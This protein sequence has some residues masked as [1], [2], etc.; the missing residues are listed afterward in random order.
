MENLLKNRIPSLDGLRAV[1]ILMVVFGHAFK[2]Y[3]KLID[4]ANLGVRIFFIISAY[5]IVGILYR[6]VKSNKFSIKTFYF[7]RLVRTFPAFYTYLLIV[8]IVLICLNL[9][10]FEQFWRAPIYLENYHPR[11]LWN[12]KQWFVGHTW[13]LAVEEQFYVL[14]AV[15]FLSYYKKWITYKQVFKIFIFIVILVPLIR[16][17]Y[18]YFHFIP[19]I[20]RG[21]V[22]RSFET[23]AD[24]LALG[25]LLAITPREKLI[26]SKAFSFLKNKI[27]LLV[28]FLLF[29]QMLNSS[30]L[31]D[32]LGLKI[33]Y[34]YNLFGLTIINLIIVSLIFILINL[35]LKSKVSLLL[36][37]PIMK[38]IG[39]WSYSIYL[40][41]QIWLYSWEI[42]LIFKFLGIIVSSVLSYYLIEKIFLTWRDTYLEKNETNKN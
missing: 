37:H 26:N 18:M 16:I 42:P 36:N 5:L 40:W 10:E 30:I 17:S 6:D 2:G 25:G 31:V 39:L 20:L 35:D 12:T 33:R 19:D 38:T 41:Q 28:A 4:I 29:F 7:K 34:I 15:M 13:S 32:Y 11:S 14:I 23:V 3:F 22:H 27:F 24:S 1:S 21:S 9:F 8:F